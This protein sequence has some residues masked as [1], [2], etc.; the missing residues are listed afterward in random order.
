MRWE[1]AVKFRKDC[2]KC[3]HV[4]GLAS[5]DRCQS[6]PHFAK[7][8]CPICGCHWDWVGSPDEKPGK[9]HGKHK[10]LT[11][12][13]Q[14]LVRFCEICLR[15]EDQM[16]DKR[17]LEGHHVLEFSDGGDATIENTLVLCPQCHALVHLI[18]TYS[19]G[20][21]VNESEL[22]LANA[23]QQQSKMDQVNG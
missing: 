5:I 21:K 15:L 14:P 19:I 2:S 13:K 16:P 20:V 12:N 23:I 3:G 4:N 6:G 1:D 18:R 22:M 17:S 11:R 9:R 7:A 10:S 8:I